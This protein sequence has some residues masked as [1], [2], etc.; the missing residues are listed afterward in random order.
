[1]KLVK[2]PLQSCIPG[3]GV[4]A[5]AV[6]LTTSATMNA[7]GLTAEEAHAIGV[8]A[9]LYFYPLITMDVTRKQFTNF[10]PGKE[11]G[12]GPMNAIWNVPAYPPA[13]DRGVVRYNFDTLYSVG[14]LNMTMEPMVVSV[15]DTGGRYYL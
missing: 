2:Q 12:R 3:V 1:M 7:A 6:W 8:E 13:S 14:W 9:Y 11:I 10:E 15:P 4:A 5:A